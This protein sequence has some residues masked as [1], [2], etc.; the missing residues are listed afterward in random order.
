MLFRWWRRRD[1][2][3]TAWREVTGRLGLVPAADGQAL[4]SDL[5]DLPA[6]V[7]LGPVHQVEQAGAA[8]VYLFWYRRDPQSRSREPSYVT[9]CLLVSEREVS[10]VSWRASRKM[11][12]VIASLQASATGGEVIAVAG[13]EEFNQR[14]T[15]VAREGS[16]LLG[17]LTPAV[18]G[19][20][21]R[22]VGRSEPP[23]AL[24]V[25]ERRILLSAPG[26]RPAFDQVEF[27]MTDVLSLYAALESV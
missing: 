4:V 1:P 26:T 14:V 25:G 7:V 10:P 27:L 22:T 5:L 8:Q 21:E 9:A 12:S 24:T 16:R 18:R 13:A 19:V 3:E 17:L 2:L 11:H 20:L 23:P 15:V 6:D